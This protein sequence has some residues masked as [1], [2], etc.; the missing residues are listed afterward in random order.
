MF[1]NNKIRIYF[2]YISLLFLGLYFN[3]NP[4]GGARQD[5]QLFQEVIK[6]FSVSINF[7][8]AEFFFKSYHHSPVFYIFAALLQKIF[9]NF[10]IL[11]VI[12]ILISS[13]IP[14]IFFLVL[15]IKYNINNLY[16]FL[17]SL[18]IFYSPYFIGTA[19]WLNGDNLSLLFFLLSIL[20]FFKSEKNN[21]KIFPILCFLFLA[22]CCYIRYYYCLFGLYYL[23]KYFYSLSKK[24]FIL[25]LILNFLLIFPAIG[26]LYEIILD[27]NFFTNNNFLSFNYLNNSLIIS[28]IILFYLVPI[29]FFET[30]KIILYY[31]KNMGLPLFLFSF[32]VFILLLNLVLNITLINPP[33]NGGGV[34]V[35]LIG[36]LNLNLNIF[37]FIIFCIFILG[38]NY[39]FLSNKIEN[40]ILLSILFLSFPL[41]TIYQKYF[42]P[43]FIIF[44]F[45]FI[46]SKIIYTNIKNKIINLYFLHLYFISFFIFCL[47]Y[48]F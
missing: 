40:Y 45:S 22:L 43:F 19:I 25:L 35:K 31:K 36:V 1:I 10:E 47:F 3:I 32:T 46:K 28:S 16:I 17:L 20:F 23:Y 39:F 5:Y 4:S 33:I 21:N 18:T 12:N 8:Y 41:A 14:Y 24:N 37:L 44:F 26:F 42:D 30:K 6:N 7:K 11:R 2:L 27:K 9:N 29:F 34:L 48:N 38:I 13:L 15:R